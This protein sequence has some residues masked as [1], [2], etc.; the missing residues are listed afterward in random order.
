MNQF[1]SRASLVS[2]ILTFLLPSMLVLLAGLQAHNFV[3]TNDDING[4]NTVSAFYVNKSGKLTPLFGSP[5]PT[6]GLGSSIGFFASNRIA[7]HTDGKFL[8]VAN[9]GSNDV[10][11]FNV[12]KL[13]GFLTLV[14]GS[15]FATGSFAS[16]G[17]SLGSTP[18]GKFLI[19]AN[20][21]SSN[22]TV[23]RVHKSGRLTQ[24]LNSPFLT[25]SNPDGIRIS[26]NGKFLTVAQPNANQIEIFQ[27]NR[28]NGA[29]TSL[30]VTPGQVTGNN[31]G[32]AGVDIDSS[33]KLLYGGVANSIETAID[34]YYISRHGT[35]S[36]ISKA[37]FVIPSGVNS[38][39]VLLNYQHKKKI[40]LVSNQNSNTIT[41][42]DVAKNGVLQL[43][44]S[45]FFMNAGA[46]R[47]SG[48]AT[49]KDGKLLYVAN[50]SNKISVF[51]V[52]HSGVLKEVKGS[53][54]PTGQNG[55][56]QALTAFP[57][58]G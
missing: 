40:L 4:P 23:F 12:N 39:V 53:P 24:I 20:S 18:D 43:V 37:P 35:L 30:G 45:P 41:S 34:G 36:S 3:Y 31:S 57:P 55:L 51:K 47:P 27:I 38:N 6:N 15:P 8:Y 56:L 25:Q 48:M 5:F 14:E 49:R 29:L 16:F 11:V 7:V 26:P 28:K 19:A 42:F 46:N 58:N 44:A 50:R 52:K 2:R 54:F 10:S 21:D 1:L 32:V 17:I 13:T 33:G 22:I 9:S